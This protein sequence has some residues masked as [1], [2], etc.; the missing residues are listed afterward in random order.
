MRDL[1]LEFLGTL[2]EVGI[3]RALFHALK[4]QLP[5]DTGALF[6]RMGNTR[7]LEV[8]RM[9]RS[10]YVVRLLN[11]VP[12]AAVPLA[13]RLL[14]EQKTLSL[15]DVR[16]EPEWRV[17]LGA[18]DTRS[19]LALPVASSAGVIGFFALSSS[20]P[21]F[22]TP[23]HTAIAELFVP[24]ASLA[25]AKSRLFEMV[26]SSRARL[27]DLGRELIST[28]EQERL[29][30]SRDLHDEAGQSL[31][32]LTSTLDGLQRAPAV[33]SAQVLTQAREMVVTIRGT[34]ERLHQMAYQL[35]SPALDLLGLNDALAGLCDEYA[36]RANLNIAYHA[37]RPDVIQ[38]EVAL[39]LYR[40]TQEALTNIVKHSQATQVDVT[41]RALPD[42]LE[43]SIADNG[44]GFDRAAV[45]G[46][47]RRQTMLGLA[48]MRERLWLVNGHLEIESQPGHGARLTVR[49]PHAS[50]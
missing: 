8:A 26:R 16:A 30:L 41:L 33:S 38:D 44:I 27:V 21:H 10:G 35:R 22:F 14:A 5:F 34:L 37:E 49:V 46:R 31:T 36:R 47:P 39:T 6:L 2:D 29:R 43:L 40:C 23:Q 18:R 17:T 42:A 32:I 19:W 12:I 24:L 3:A 28:Q 4:Q 11:I 9:D 50:D 20:R 13:R 45:L 25:I 1:G 7:L 48:G 15:V